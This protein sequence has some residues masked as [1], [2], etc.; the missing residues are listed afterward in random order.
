MLVCLLG[1][2]VGRAGF[3]LQRNNGGGASSGSIMPGSSLP[4]A[5]DASGRGGASSSDYGFDTAGRQAMEEKRAKMIISE[6][7]KMMMKEADQILQSAAELQASVSG[8]ADPSR[9]DTFRKAES[10][11]KLARNVKDRMKGS[12]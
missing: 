6:R 5:S 3:G 4:S 7:Q 10:I 1:V 11:E 8:S 2:G 12:R 9:E